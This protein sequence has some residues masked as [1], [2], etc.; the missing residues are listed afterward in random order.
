MARKM[1]LPM[2]LNVL[3]VLAS[4]DTGQQFYR[5]PPIYPPN[6]LDFL[7]A[8]DCLPPI[9]EN[10]LD[11]TP[12]EHLSDELALVL[13]QSAVGNVV[14]YVVIP[15]DEIGEDGFEDSFWDNMQEWK[16]LLNQYPKKIVAFTDNARYSKRLDEFGFQVFRD[17]HYFQMLF[18]QAGEENEL[19]TFRLMALNEVILSF[20]YET[21]YV[22]IG[23]ALEWS[24]DPFHQFATLDPQGD[25][26]FSVDAFQDGTSTPAWT[27]KPL[28][29]P[30]RSD[31][32]DD[33]HDCCRVQFLPWSNAL[34]FT[35]PTSGAIRLVRQ[36][37][38]RSIPV[39]DGGAG[40]CLNHQA[41]NLALVEGCASVA[42]RTLDP[43][44][45][46]SEA[47]Q[48]HGRFVTLAEVEL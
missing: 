48:I 6:H 43:F 30:P 46:P 11:S 37:K 3:V 5:H 14:F 28:V 16:R 19:R 45:F 40:R 29:V 34:M 4:T 26:F 41:H 44:H 13:K 15:D 7:K 18:S 32:Q 8:Y 35:R 47:H 42:C 20:G 10:K 36:M 21:F 27:L 2:F 33:E 22:D 17:S 25:I 38:Q 31:Q 23:N 12:R 1:Q 39:K 24:E 9:D